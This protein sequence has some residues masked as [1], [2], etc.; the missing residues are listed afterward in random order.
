MEEVWRDISIVYDFSP[1]I[2]EQR[3]RRKLIKI[4][5]NGAILIKYEVEEDGHKVSLD[6]ICFKNVSERSRCN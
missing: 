5:E 3:L 4:G 1:S 2:V 6:A